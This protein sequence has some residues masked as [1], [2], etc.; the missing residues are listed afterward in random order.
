MALSASGLD[1]VAALTH[2]AWPSRAPASP[3]AAAQHACGCVYAWM[4]LMFWLLNP[5]WEVAAGVGCV[6]A[7]V[8]VVAAVVVETGA[9]CGWWFELVRSAVLKLVL[10]LAH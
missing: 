8:C 9:W 5:V 4:V 6:G 2:V 1:G 7:V 3:Q 10:L